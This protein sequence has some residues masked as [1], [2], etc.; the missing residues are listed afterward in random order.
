MPSVYTNILIPT[1]DLLKPLLCT[2]I[3]TKYKTTVVL[4]KQNMQLP[5]IVIRRDTVIVPN[6]RM[7]SLQT[8]VLIQS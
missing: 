5:R 3:T 2:P 4:N 8:T 1:K 7:T 6:G